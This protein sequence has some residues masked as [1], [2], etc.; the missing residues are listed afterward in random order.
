[1]G[2]FIAYEQM[3]DMY[4]ELAWSYKELYEETHDLIIDFGPAP[5]PF[6]PL[7]PLALLCLFLTIVLLIDE[8]R[9]KYD[10]RAEGEP[11]ANEPQEQFLK[12]LCR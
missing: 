2:G 1:V 12:F 11:K 9:Q 5:N 6:A 3:S 8:I 10:E 4:W 7:I